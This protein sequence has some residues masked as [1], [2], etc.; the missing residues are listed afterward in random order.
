MS[1]PTSGGFATYI[2]KTKQFSPNARLVLLYSAIT[3]LAFGVFRFL[4][5]FYVL[6]LGDTYNE[7]FIGSLQTASSFASIAMALPAAYLAER[8]SQKKI[9]IHTAVISS[10]AIVGLVLFPFRGLLILFNMIAGISMS[11]RQVAMAPFLMA[12]T[13]ENERQ[14]VFSFNF[15]LMTVSGFFGNLLGGWLPTW[16]GNSFDAAPTDTLSYQLALGSMMIVTIL[17]I[18]PLTRII[19]P[20]VDRERRVELPWVQ[21]RRYG[22]SLSQFLL[23]QLI[24]GLG[25][26]LM[27]PFMNIYFRNVYEKPD[28]PISMVFAIGGLAMAIAQFLGPPLADK[29][30][31]INTVILTQIF[32]V[33]FL[34]LLGLG[35]WLVPGGMAAASIWF[36]IASL[37]YIFRLALMNLSNPVY[38]TFVLEHVP[39]DVQALAMSLNSLSFQ[40]GWFIMPQVSG[41][42]QVRFG[43]FGFVPIFGMVAIFYVLATGLEWW[44]FGRRNRQMPTF[45]PS[46]GD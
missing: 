2:E 24:I 13:S 45:V 31:K 7:A 29:Y 4:F 6:S 37:A 9:M 16:L 36:F 21:L 40:F 33:P 39:T 3:G 11:M 43:E 38:Q 25:A 14:W 19:M 32:S 30:G 5:N 28:P 42:L 15:G 46:A 23:P 41:W 20:P 35:A 22:W 34:L 18:G 8:Y 12:N 17:S 10:L 44:L 1:Q 26:G 27:Q